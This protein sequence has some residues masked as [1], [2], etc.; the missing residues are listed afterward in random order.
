M[1]SVV[2]KAFRENH[3]E[4]TIQG[5]SHSVN[6]PTIKRCRSYVQSVALVPGDSG[7]GRWQTICSVIAVSWLRFFVSVNVR[8]K[9]VSMSSACLQNDHN[10]ASNNYVKANSKSFSNRI[11]ERK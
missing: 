1:N 9:V 3:E 8:L 5:M 2:I 11:I 6:I 4:A 10:Y 7:G